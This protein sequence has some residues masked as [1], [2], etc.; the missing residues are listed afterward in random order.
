M[1]QQERKH[2]Q[3][4]N[5]TNPQQSQTFARFSQWLRAWSRKALLRSQD[6]TTPPSQDHIATAPQRNRT[7]THTHR[8]APFPRHVHA[9]R[10][11]RKLHQRARGGCNARV[12]QGQTLTM[13]QWHLTPSPVKVA[14]R[15]WA[16][17]RFTNRSQ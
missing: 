11:A 12:D 16:P 3:T 6:H 7:K 10:R 13:T 5:T 15:L 8:D 4:H 2:P 14:E 9:T 17:D 1:Q